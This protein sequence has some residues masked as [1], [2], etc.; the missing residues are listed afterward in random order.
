[1]PGP[2]NI[3]GVRQ[4]I[5]SG[6]VLGR[7]APGASRGQPHLVPLP[8]TTQQAIISGAGGKA[9]AGG[10]FG[11]P[12]YIQ[13][14]GTTTITL[15]NSGLVLSGGPAYVIG[16]NT[17]HIP[18]VG[19]NSNAAAGEVGEY[20][21]SNIHGTGPGLPDG[22]VV[23]ITSISLTAGDW[24][25]SGNVVTSGTT[26]GTIT[27]TVIGAFSI[28]S[29]T[30]PSD[31]LGYSEINYTSGPGAG[32]ALAIPTRRYS[33]NGTT[34]VYLVC[35]TEHTGGTGIASSSGY[36]GARRCR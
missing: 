35:Y 27:S 3:R 15:S 26:A 13:A 10:G 5:P 19:N 16:T 4:V 7:S 36:V 24:D 21:L 23:D 14:A 2:R 17:G 11:G 12:G 28:S 30:L 31:F 34:T 1:M 20:I 32:M 6:F 22:T 8:P 18:G 33:F 29:A 25:V 9:T